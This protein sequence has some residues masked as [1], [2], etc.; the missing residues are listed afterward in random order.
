M[1]QRSPSK[2][3]EREACTPEADENLRIGLEER[4]LT[5]KEPVADAVGEV[6]QKDQKSGWLVESEEGT[7]ELV[8]ASRELKN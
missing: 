2:K 6:G 1:E 4:C 3:R 5:K 8:P 7:P